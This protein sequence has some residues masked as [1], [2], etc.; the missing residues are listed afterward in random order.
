MPG[1][2]KSYADAAQA[3][4]ALRRTELLRAQSVQTPAAKPGPTHCELAFDRVEGRTGRDLIGQDMGALLQSVAQLHGASVPNLSP[5]DPLLRI[6]PRL[7]LTNVPLF[8]DI[9]NGQV[10]QGKSVLH[11][12]LHVGQFIVT[13]E[14]AVWL[15]DLDDLA[16]GP[17]EAD[18]A[19]LAAHLATTEPGPGIEGWS[20]TV[21]LAW[22]AL[23]R[24]ADR[25]VFTRYLH[26]A[27]LRRHLKL[28]EAGR[29]DFQSTLLAY[30]R[31]SSS[32]SIR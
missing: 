19:N 29:P 24:S 28:R 32:F 13:P 6:R 20:Q 7:A 10:P 11:G 15:V 2:L 4:E 26:L 14:G 8:R 16:I 5:F 21:C 17:P 31:E 9:A 30:F 12:D 23:G 1:F 3:V 25:K 22:E 27:L 18:F